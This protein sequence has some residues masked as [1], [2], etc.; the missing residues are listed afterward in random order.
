MEH[1]LKGAVGLSVGNVKLQPSA[2]L[3]RVL[4]E[5]GGTIKTLNDVCDWKPKYGYLS[6][7]D[8][9]ERLIAIHRAY[10]TQFLFCDK[11]VTGKKIIEILTNNER[12]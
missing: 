9:M 1:G 4:I 11:R 7:R 12:N 5:H 3:P 10:G 2:G 6:G 8:V